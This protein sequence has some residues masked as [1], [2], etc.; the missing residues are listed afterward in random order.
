MVSSPLFSIVLALIMAMPLSLNAQQ[1]P[2]LIGT[3]TNGK[4]ELA[5]RGIYTTTLDLESGKLSEVKLAAEAQNPGFLTHHPEKDFVYAVAEGSSFNGEAGGGV[6]AFFRDRETGLLTHINS[7]AVGANGP[8]HL[9]IDR[10]G[11]VLFTANYGGGSVSV[12]P[13]LPDGSLGARSDFQQHEGSGPLEARQ[14][15]PHAH[16]ITISQDNR[17]VIVP[18]LGID[19]LKIYRLDVENAKLEPAD[20][21]FAALAPGAG[22]RHFSF[23]PDGLHGYCVNELDNT[24]TS[25]S[26]D[27]DQGV[28]TPS[29]SF[30]TLP[31]AWVGKN[32]TAEIAL[33][34]SGSH[35]VVSNRGH[36]SLAVFRRDAQ[37]GALALVDIFPCGGN[38]PRS[39]A[40]SPD[41]NW[42]VVGHQTSDTLAVFSF[43]SKTGMMQ[44]V[45]ETIDVP[46]PICVLFDR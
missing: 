13:V 45:G 35:V 31:T 29:G 1:A 43:D 42:I 23:S 34:P 37:S 2:L 28:L 18:D 4:G 15:G 36:D 9:A 20:P 27:T 5:S 40:F 7:R 30:S 10:T 46:K 21:A 6:V 19:Q 17:F 24:V 14:K 25:F 16:G 44:Q 3:N 11:R 8:C 22:P 26:W 33:H 39:F 12:F 41:G 38:G 32:T